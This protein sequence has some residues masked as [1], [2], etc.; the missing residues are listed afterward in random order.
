[1][2]I[3]FNGWFGGFLDKTN[4]GLNVEFF[5]ELFEKIY[6]EK[7]QVGKLE[8]SSILCECCMLHN[9]K[10]KLNTKKWKHTF[11][12]SG[13]NDLRACEPY[14]DQYDCILWMNRNHKNIVNVPLH[15]PYIYT[16]NFL[17]SLEKQKKRESVPQNDVL[18]VISNPN[19][20]QRN[21][22][23][24]ALEKKMKVT[25][26]GRYKNNI[27]QLLPWDYNKPEFKNFVSQF[28]F[29]ISMENTKYETGVT[30]KITHG[31]LSQTIPVYWG[32]P[33]VHDYFN[34]ERFLNLEKADDISIDNVIN[35]MIELKNDNKKWLD[36]VNNNVFPGN[37][38]LWRTIDEIAK[39]IRCLL[40]KKPFNV[41]DRIHVIC[42]EKYEP[43]RYSNLTEMFKNLKVNNDYIRYI[44]PTYKHTI[45]NKMY[46]YHCKK[47]LVLRMR[48]SGP[49]MKKAE[50]SITLNFKENY[51][52]IVKNFKD[53]I[54]LIF[55]SDILISKDIDKINDFLDEIKDKDWDSI[56]L[57]QFSNC[58]IFG[59]PVTP[60]IS[61]YRNYGEPF[62]QELVRY[63]QQNRKNKKYIEDNK[64][65]ND[66]YRLIRKF[67]PRC[68]DCIIWK[69]DS[70][71]KYLN[72]MNKMEKDFSCPAD[73]LFL[74]F[75]EN[76]IDFKH[77][78]SVDEFFKQGSNIGLIKSTIQCD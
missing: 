51:E 32:S 33:S 20:P 36:M 63:I 30:E 77:Y 54:F 55:E 76:N 27:G 23:L 24:L 5:L 69:Y 10:T 52:N 28:K 47:Q 75:L 46:E 49:K 9:A 4:P 34:K 62:P 8:E 2:K 3:F 17:P 50:L 72:F 45:T 58:D 64:R 60:W 43:V 41:I 61:G 15:I 44:C 78:W 12:M 38:K 7:C 48:P 13:E 74:H 11:M 67:H 1:M 26:A 29:I 16:N 37:G 14:K 59:E 21:K 18:V 25:Y 22:F 56:H 70:I 19:G 42:N 68:L 73:Y 66:K 71:V 40:N 57:G 39:D 35:K 53:G 65:D 6:N 31:M